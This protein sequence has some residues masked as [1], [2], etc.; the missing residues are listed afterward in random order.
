MSQNDSYAEGR[1]CQCE[2][3]RAIDEAEGTPMGSLLTFVNRI[4]DAIKDDYPHVA[5]DTLAYRYTRKAPKTI[6]PADNV[7]IRPHRSR[8]GTRR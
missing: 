6:V 8:S 5:V 4:A 2:K 1:G 3:C 7:I